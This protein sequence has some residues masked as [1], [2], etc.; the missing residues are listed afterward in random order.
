MVIYPVSLLPM[1][2]GM[3]IVCIADISA[4]IAYLLTDDFAIDMGKVNYGGSHGAR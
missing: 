4:P 1:I 2:Q 3:A